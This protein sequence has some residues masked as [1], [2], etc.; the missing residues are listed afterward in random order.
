MDHKKIARLI[1]TIENDPRSAAKILSELPTHRSKVI[2]FTGSPGVGKSSLIDRVVKQIRAGDFSA[3]V[4]AVDP[5]SP[6]SM[7]AF[8]GDRIRM[9]QHFL[10][11]KVFI[12]SIASRGALGGLSDA[13]FDIVR[14]LES[15]G[16]D[17]V[18]VET[19]GV[20]QSETEISKLADVTVLILSPGFG[21]D[22]QMLKAGVMEIADIY[23]VNKSDL[24]DSA[25]L[26]S[27]L[28]AFASL[29]GKS[30]SCIC[31]TSAH[32][33]HGVEELLERIEKL[34]KEFDANG[35]LET[36]RKR[37]TK[38]HAEHILRKILQETIDKVQIETADPYD[39][40]RETMA[41]LCD[42]R[43]TIGQGGGT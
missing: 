24:P 38:H 14:L 6:F 18:L 41:R 20:G 21:D 30:E 12:R 36:R 5:S 28:L 22:V 35:T 43:S 9:R 27:Q 23:V 34:W 19:V 26:Y 3:A 1:S 8:L 37:R 25:T 29:A 10:D 33:Q 11:E 4:I 40:V 2:G 15:V 17:Y 42:L 16:F 7:G 32:L 31:R 13:V 39:F